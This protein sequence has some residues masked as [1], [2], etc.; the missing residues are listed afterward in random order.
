M[1]FSTGEHTDSIFTPETNKAGA[2]LFTKSAEFLEATL[3]LLLKDRRLL[4][5]QITQ[6]MA[7]QI[8]QTVNS[9]LMG[10]LVAP[11]QWCPKR[12]VAIQFPYL[13]L[14]KQIKFNQ[15]IILM[16]DSGEILWC[17]KYLT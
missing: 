8:L 3:M 9:I 4:T 2:D 7:L 6:R 1:G 16:E 10:T 17:Q 14:Q 11:I 13:Q 5:R 12:T 15:L